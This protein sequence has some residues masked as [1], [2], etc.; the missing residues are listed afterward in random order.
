MLYGMCSTY[1]IRRPKG[2]QGCSKNAF[3][4]DSINSFFVF[5]LGYGGFPEMHLANSYMAMGQ[6]PSE[7]QIGELFSA[8]H[9]L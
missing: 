4:L 1:D 7:L 9:S 6:R 8:F 3:R 5:W 2:A